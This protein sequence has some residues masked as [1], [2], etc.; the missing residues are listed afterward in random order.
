MPRCWKLPHVPPCR[1]AATLSWLEAN[2]TESDRTD[3]GAREQARRQLNAEHTRLQTRIETMYLDRLDGWIT[4]AFFDEKSK[5]WRHRRKEIE[6]RVLQL[7]ATGLRSA[8][9]AA[10]IMKSVSEACTGFGDAKPRQQRALATALLADAT[11]TAGKSESGWKA[12]FD[13]LALSNAA[14]R[15][16]ESEKSGSERDIQICLPT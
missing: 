8:T 15:S 5:E 16:Q 3:A 11:W 6:A 14:S 4:A 9:D 13:V 2:V 1:K 12:P 7:A 10:Q